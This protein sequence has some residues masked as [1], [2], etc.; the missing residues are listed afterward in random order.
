MKIICVDNFA[1][2]T[3]ADTLVAEG[4]TSKEYAECM[5]N[6]LI[7]K[8]SYDSSPYWYRIVEDDYRLWKGMEEFV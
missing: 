7:A 6:A 1:R 5:L 4:I 8:Y 2:E 3:V